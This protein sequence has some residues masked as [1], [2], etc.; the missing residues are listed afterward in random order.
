MFSRC[1]NDSSKLYFNLRNSR[2]ITHFCVK[3]MNVI[4]ITAL[5]GMEEIWIGYAI[6]CSWYHL[7][8]QLHRQCHW[9]PQRI[10]VHCLCSYNVTC[11]LSKTYQSYKKV[12]NTRCLLLTSVGHAWHQQKMYYFLVCEEYSFE[13]CGFLTVSFLH[14]TNAMGRNYCLGKSTFWKYHK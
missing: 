2:F 8:L 1:R 7:P 3:C 10:S 6:I 13:W 5:S 14:D 11:G 4:H 12:N 9:N